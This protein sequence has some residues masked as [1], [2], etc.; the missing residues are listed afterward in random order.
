MPESRLLCELLSFERRLD[1]TLARRYVELQEAVQQPQHSTQPLRLAVWHEW[2]QLQGAGAAQWAWTLRLL[3]SWVDD[4]EGSVGV[5][6]GVGAPL[7]VLGSVLDSLVVQLDPAVFPGDDG[8]VEWHKHSTAAATDGFEVHRVASTACAVKLFLYPDYSPPLFSLSTA[9]ARVLGVRQATHVQLLR[10]LHAY[11][12]QHDLHVLSPTDGSGLI[13]PDDA[14]SAVL[15]ASTPVTL[16]Q[17]NERIS[18]Q[19]MFAAEPIILSYH[20]QKP[21]PTTGASSS[22]AAAYAPAPPSTVSVFDISLPVPELPALA[23]MGPILQST[24]ASFSAAANGASVVPVLSAAVAPV[25]ATVTAMAA[26][27]PTPAAAV[28]VTA[29]AVSSGPVSGAAPS[30]AVASS[31]SSSSGPLP[32]T[33]P[34]LSKEWR[35]LSGLGDTISAHLTELHRLARRRDLLHA[36]ASCPLETLQLL[37]T[38]QTRHVM[39]G[40]TTQRAEQAERA[41]RLEQ[42]QQAAEQ[43]ALAAPQAH[44]TTHLHL[45]ASRS[46]ALTQGEEEKARRGRYYTADWMADAV[47]R[48]LGH[49][50]TVAAAGGRDRNVP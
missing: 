16:Q 15:G 28:A 31:S 46:V 4:S 3:G 17:L 32:P 38:Q 18:A 33:P 5:G 1:C 11:C 39:N 12:T 22:S 7:R 34:S 30:S 37:L 43:A 8:L 41:V 2:Q 35:E 25:P 24:F 44:S 50:Q 27:T 9:L 19:H 36:F 29:S 20:I 13:S 48:Y 49:T 40:L 14:L 45:G 47:D 26:G 42:Q 6:S 10:S 21:P 23:T